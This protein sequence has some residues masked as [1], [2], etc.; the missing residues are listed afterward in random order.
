M[1]KIKVIILLAFC[2]IGLQAQKYIQEDSK[3][4]VD[5]KI[6]NLGFYVDCKFEKINFEVSFDKNDLANSYINAIIEV[7]SLDTDNETRNKSLAEEKYFNTAKHPNITLKSSKIEYVDNNT[8]NVTGNL[9]IKGTTKKVIIPIQ[10][11]EKSNHL[12][13]TS[14]FTLNRLDYKV[15][16]GSLILSKSVIA[17]VNYFG[18]K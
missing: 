15:G 7:S 8:Y 11:T 12:E 17:K 9:T 10:V 16:K 4:T 1:K 14:D 18:A 5:F 2:T 13:I 6:K 3:T